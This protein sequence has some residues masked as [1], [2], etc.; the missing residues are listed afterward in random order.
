M[1]KIAS[2]KRKVY[3]NECLFIIISCEHEDVK[4]VLLENF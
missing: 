3:R 1:N 4:S 2:F